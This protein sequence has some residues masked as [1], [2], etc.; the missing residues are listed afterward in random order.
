VISTIG[1]TRNAE[2]LGWIDLSVGNPSYDPPQEAKDAANRALADGRNEYLPP[3]GLVGLRQALTVK[4]HEQNCIPA[5]MDDV[6][7]TTGA[8]LG[9]FAAMSALCQPGDRILIPDPCFPLYRLIAQ[10]QRLRPVYYPM[11]ADSEY[12][13]DWDVI[14]QA[15]PNVRI[16][17]WNS[18]SNPLGAIATKESLSRLA[19]LLEVNPEVYLVSDEVYENLVF[20]GVHLS[21]ATAF[22]SLADRIFS[23]FSFSKTYAMA[24]WR[25]GYVHAPSIWAGKLEKVQWAAGMSPPTIAQYA[26]V[27]ALQAPHSYHEQILGFLRHNRAEA[28]ACLRQWQLPCCDPQGAFFVWVNI[29]SSGLNSIT[30]AARCSEECRV[31]VSPGAHFSTSAD[32]HV[33]LCIAVDTGRLIEGLDR[34]GRWVHRLSEYS[35]EKCTNPPLLTED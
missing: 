34:I 2:E 27:A 5:N 3:R 32:H 11:R 33:R 25:I 14:A 10:T 24:G 35:T 26:A 1:N 22:C 20:S 18:P 23:V 12:Q 13:P 28:V 6:V 7:I 16:L 19:E 15:L 29:R 9:L 4:L 17:L 30:F 8:S 21:P 31:V